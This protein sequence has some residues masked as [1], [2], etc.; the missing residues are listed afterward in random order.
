MSNDAS[1]RIFT[2]KLDLDDAEQMADLAET[3][4]SNVKNGTGALR[5]PE[6]PLVQPAA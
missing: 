3:F 2:G 6:V 1:R 4:T 5:L